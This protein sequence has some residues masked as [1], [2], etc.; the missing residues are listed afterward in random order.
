MKRIIC[1][2]THRKYWTK[3]KSMHYAD[4]WTDVKCTKCKTEFTFS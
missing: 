2:L 1:F 4:H 3:K